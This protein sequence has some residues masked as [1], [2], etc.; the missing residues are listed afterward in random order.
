MQTMTDSWRGTLILVLFL[1]GLPRLGSAQTFSPTGSMVTAR[2]SHTA[3]L[4]SNGKVLVAGG[5]DS[6]GTPLA[7]AEL[8]TRPAAPFPPQAT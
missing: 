5:E 8:T 4:L 1:I 7:S 2:D 3:T 6:S